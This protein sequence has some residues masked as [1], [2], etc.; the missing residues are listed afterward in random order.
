MT[1]ELIDKHDPTNIYTNEWEALEVVVTDPCLEAVYA[2]VKDNPKP[3]D[4]WVEITKGT[5][6]TTEWPFT[7]DVNDKYYEDF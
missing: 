4:L 3:E 6:N 7:N 1:G 2:F 5:F